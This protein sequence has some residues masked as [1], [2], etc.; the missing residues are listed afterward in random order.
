MSN[1]VVNTIPRVTIAP[2]A[3]FSLESEGF[4]FVATKRNPSGAPWGGFPPQE[5]R[6][7]FHPPHPPGAGAPNIHSPLTKVKNTYI[8][9]RRKPRIERIGG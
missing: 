6:G 5:S 2:K 9:C 1:R 3:F 7:G 4:L 8:I